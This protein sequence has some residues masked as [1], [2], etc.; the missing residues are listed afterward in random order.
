MRAE[1]VCLCLCERYR[2]RDR[3]RVKEKERER[4]TEPCAESSCRS[5]QS[6]NREGSVIISLGNDFVKFALLRV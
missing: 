4:G 3:E 2:Q 6:I 1:C 5:P